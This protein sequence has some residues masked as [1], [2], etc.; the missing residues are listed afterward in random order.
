MPGIGEIGELVRIKL[1]NRLNQIG[2]LVK[3]VNLSGSN[4]WIGDIKLVNWWN[5]WI[6]QDQIG[7]LVKSNWWNQIGELVKLVNLSGSKRA[8]KDNETNY[9]HQEL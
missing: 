1:V 4:W 5:W 9:Q 7:E 8:E 6:C 2:V 3:L